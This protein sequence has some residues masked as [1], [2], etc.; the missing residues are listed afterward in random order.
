MWEDYAPDNYPILYP[1]IKEED[2][3]TEV[4]DQY[5]RRR[6]FLFPVFDF[7]NSSDLPVSEVSFSIEENDK[8]IKWNTRRRREPLS[9]GSRIS[10]SLAYKIDLLCLKRRLYEQESLNSKIIEI[11]NPEEALD[12]AGLKNSLSLYELDEALKYIFSTHLLFSARSF[13]ENGTPPLPGSPDDLDS[14]FKAYSGHISREINRD[15]KKI[16]QYR[17]KIDSHY[18]ELMLSVPLIIFDWEYMKNLEAGEL[19]FY[20]L[21]N[22]LRA[23]STDQ[24]SDRLEIEYNIFTRLMPLPTLEGYPQIKRQIDELCRNHIERQYLQKLRITKNKKGKDTDNP[25]LSFTF[26]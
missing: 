19:R 1:G 13:T 26:N 18:L 3:F 14:G 15:G 7:T 16:T 20:E 11:T 10:E 24:P 4:E 21:T 17:I 2:L 9:G 22:L 25:I 12:S 23:V 6:I 8:K 5:I